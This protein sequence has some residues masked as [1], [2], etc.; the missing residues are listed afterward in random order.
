[1][2]ISGGF[3]ANPVTYTFRHNCILRKESVI[4]T[5]ILDTQGFLSESHVAIQ[6]NYTLVMLKQSH[7][8]NAPK[9]IQVLSG[10][11]SSHQNHMTKTPVHN[12]FH[13]LS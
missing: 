2:C 11:F 4:S 3:F 6:V 9:A 7:K 12:R 8:M 10:D 13:A 5:F 1:M